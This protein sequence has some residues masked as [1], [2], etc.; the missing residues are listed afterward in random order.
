MI[1]ERDTVEASQFMPPFKG[2]VICR[3]PSETMAGDLCQVEDEHGQ[4]RWFLDWQLRKVEVEP[5]ELEEEVGIAE[6]RQMLSERG[7]AHR[8]WD[9]KSA[10]LVWQGNPKPEEPKDWFVGVVLADARMSLVHR[11]ASFGTNVFPMTK[12]EAIG[13]VDRMTLLNGLQYRAFHWPDGVS[14]G[15]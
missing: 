12:A 7:V 15:H 2:K 6:A 4:A 3:I 13:L 14:D 1:R 9:I 11:E 8:K 5:V 10:K